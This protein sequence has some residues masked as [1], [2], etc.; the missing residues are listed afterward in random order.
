VPKGRAVTVD[1]DVASAS[2]GPSL[3][4]AETQ[5]G[6]GSGDDALLAFGGFSIDNLPAGDYLMRA[7]VKLDGK[8]VGRVMRTIRKSK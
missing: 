4:T 8:A 7:T 6:K 5:I 1:L 2:N 3:A